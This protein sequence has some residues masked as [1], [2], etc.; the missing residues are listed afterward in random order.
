MPQRWQSSIHKQPFLSTNYSLFLRR[1]AFNTG[2][3]ITLWG[4]VIHRLEQGHEILMQRAFDELATLGVQFPSEI[5]PNWLT[6]GNIR[7]D[8][9]TLEIEERL[10][11]WW[12]IVKMIV[13]GSTCS[14]A[15]N[16]PA[17]AMRCRRQKISEAYAAT[18]Q[19]IIDGFRAGCDPTL[20][21]QARALRFGSALHTL[22]DSYAT[23]HCQRVDNGDPH[24]PIIDFYTYPSR[25]HPISTARDDIWQDSE[26]TALKRE[27]AAAITATVAA[28]RL[29]ISQSLDGLDHFLQNYLAFREDIS[30][31]YHPN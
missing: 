7:T 18:R 17:H 4:R 25:R 15:A 1:C 26:K 2:T 13:V 3:D 21:W 30:A 23:G 12:R 11:A 29:F 6:L 19:T 9:D 16:H 28:L 8:I 14:E 22:Q 24:S 10:V 5:D 31:A 20:S 27:A